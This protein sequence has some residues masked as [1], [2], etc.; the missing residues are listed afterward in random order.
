MMVGDDDDNDDNNRSYMSSKSPP[1]SKPP[2]ET[3]YVELRGQGSR[4]GEVGEPEDDENVGNDG[5]SD[6]E[7]ASKRLDEENSPVPPSK[8]PNHSGEPPKCADN[9]DMSR[10]SEDTPRHDGM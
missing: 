10:N 6:A 7:A 1:Q 3:E 5:G 4:D 2:D 8:P 9:R